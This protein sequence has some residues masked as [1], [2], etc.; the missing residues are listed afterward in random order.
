MGFETPVSFASIPAV[1][2]KP[3]V[4]HVNPDGQDKRERKDRQPRRNG[5]NRDDAPHPI[6]NAQG[7]ITGKLIDITA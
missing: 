2:A 1:H 6:P 3:D 4:G 5:D 7:Q